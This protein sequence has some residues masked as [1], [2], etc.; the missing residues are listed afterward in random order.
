MTKNLPVEIAGWLMTKFDL[1]AGCWVLL[2]SPDPQLGA[3]LV[4][5]APVCCNVIYGQS[6]QGYDTPGRADIET[7]ELQKIVLALRD[8]D[9]L[10]SPDYTQ[11][12]GF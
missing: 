2:V 12:T 9:C 10:P 5:R 3:A 8:S 11:R 6:S 7:K 4:T 1:A